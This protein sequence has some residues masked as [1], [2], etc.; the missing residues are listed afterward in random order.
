VAC[1]LGHVADEAVSI[2]AVKTAI[3]KF[4]QLD[5]LVLNAGTLNPVAQ[6]Q[7]ANVDDWRR[8][9]ET[10][11][12]SLISMIKHSLPHLRKSRG[13]VVMISSGSATNPTIGWGSY[14]ATKA[15]M[16]SL[17]QTLAVEEPD[18]AT[19]LIRP[20]KLSTG[21]QDD[22]RDSCMSLPLLG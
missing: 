11:F 7:N 3:D 2:Q 5:S 20:G 22:I 9:F 19:I 17:G 8:G 1:V 12:F 14:G 4:Q 18:I 6:L 16:N 13:R 10:N 21:I 15:A